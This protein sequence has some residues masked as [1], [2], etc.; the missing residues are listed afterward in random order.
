V[1]IGSRFEVIPPDIKERWLVNI[2]DL[3]G[4]IY[5][6]SFINAGESGISINTDGMSASVYFV[7]VSNLLSDSNSIHKVVIFE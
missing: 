1:R 4:K 5:L 3:H 2:Y 7:K 6:E